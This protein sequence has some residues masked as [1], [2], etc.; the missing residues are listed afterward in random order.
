MYRCP[1]EEDRWGA[2]PECHSKIRSDFST[3]EE[4]PE[5]TQTLPMPTVLQEPC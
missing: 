2:G 3:N 1:E 4:P 5:S